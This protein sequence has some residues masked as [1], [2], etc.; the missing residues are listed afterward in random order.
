MGMKQLQTSAQW[1][2]TYIDRI[3]DILKRTYP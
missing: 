2:A 3:F 1:P